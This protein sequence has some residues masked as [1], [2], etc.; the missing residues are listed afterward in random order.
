[1]R[2]FL[3]LVML[4]ALTQ[5]AAAE[6]QDCRTIADPAL[7]LTCYDKINPPV[8]TYPIPLPKP[9]HAIPITRPDG[10]VDY[11]GGSSPTSDDDSMVNAKLHGICRG[12]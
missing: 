10:T 9:T 4:C 5:R 2:S 7:R 8:A 3:L 6:A 1:M 11:L 12:C